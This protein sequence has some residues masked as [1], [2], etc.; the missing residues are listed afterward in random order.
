MELAIILRKVLCGGVLPT[1]E[2]LD[3]FASLKGRLD[4]LLALDRRVRGIGGQDAI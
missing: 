1:D 2:S 4:A 3:G